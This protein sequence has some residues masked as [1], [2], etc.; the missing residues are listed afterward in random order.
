MQIK[1]L[2]NIA[3]V[4][5]IVLCCFPLI[6]ENIQASKTITVTSP[7]SGDIYYQEES[8]A[9]TWT[10]N[11]TIDNVKI[12]LYSGTSTHLYTITSSTS[13]DGYYLWYVPDNYAGSNYRIK[14]TDINDPSSYD[15][16]DSFQILSQYVTV[17]SPNT[18][19]TC[20]K[21]GR[22]QI[23]WD[24]QIKSSSVD[25]G[26]LIGPSYYPIAYSTPNDGVY[27]WTVSESLATNYYYQIKIKSDENSQFYDTSSYFTIQEVNIEI[28]SPEQDDVLKIGETYG[29]TWD[30]GV[31]GGEV[32]INLYQ[33]SYNVGLIVRTDCDGVYNWDVSDE[34][35]SG[36]SYQIKITSV[37]DY[38]NYDYTGYF[39][40]RREAIDI[41]PSYTNLTLYKGYEKIITWT[42]ENAGLYINISLYKDNDYYLT[43]DSNT[44]IYGYYSWVLPYTIETYDLYRIKITSLS[45][46]N[47][48][49]YTDYFKIDEKWIKILSP[50]ENDTCYIGGTIYILWDSKNAGGN[51]SIKLSHPKYD[52]H[53]KSGYQGSWWRQIISRTYNDGNVSWTVPTNII[54]QKGF[55]LTIES[56]S[57]SELYNDSGFFPILS[58]ITITCLEKDETW[59]RGKRYD[60]TWDSQDFISDNVAIE[61]Y[62]DDN[63][64]TY[65]A[66]N[67]KN[68]GYYSWTVPQDY[69]ASTTYSIKIS[70]SS[71]PNI[72]TMSQGYM[73]LEE[74]PFFSGLN[75]MI[76]L[77]VVIA[78]VSIF[79]IWFFKW[80][81]SSFKL[82]SKK[83]KSGEEKLTQIEEHVDEIPGEID[84]K[85]RELSQEEYEKIWENER[86]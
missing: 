34:Y 63:T 79:L 75:L 76:I 83:S 86:F 3:I 49:D 30:G 74:I 82:F 6:S 64:Y 21:G 36:Y 68:D 62:K 70:D 40:I 12:E 67:T 81:K 55:Y 24:A 9:I 42:N 43:I 56:S 85:S 38:D 25:I 16:S 65:I 10:S 22:Y 2:K 47:I 29:I 84:T 8:Y 59:V 23:T 78:V 52:S 53:S 54:P 1:Q 71:N 15:F 19:S 80:K 45:D 13:D 27:D 33:N 20:Y 61:L 4:V 72:Y 14:I 73:G 28:T 7:N 77:L 69:E 32:D 46:S 58:P 60:I 51:V 44:S 66:E 18:F 17:L 26:L 50:T 57:D 41:Y 11:N 48:Y 37:S 5:L 31:S 35:G 39:T